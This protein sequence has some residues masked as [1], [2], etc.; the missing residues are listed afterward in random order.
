VRIRKVASCMGRIVI[1]QI[2]I[3]DLYMASHCS[4]AGYRNLVTVIYDEPGT[5]QNAACV[6]TRTRR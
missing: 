2:Y 5:P 1:R 4:G 6:T 3:V